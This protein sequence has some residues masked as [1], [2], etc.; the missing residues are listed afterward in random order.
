M[1]TKYVLQN[2]PIWDRISQT[3]KISNI[4]FKLMLFLKYGWN[5]KAKGA[6]FSRFTFDGY[7]AFVFFNKLF[8]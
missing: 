5:S 6:S 1:T 8:T 3:T 4:L 2:Y 7:F